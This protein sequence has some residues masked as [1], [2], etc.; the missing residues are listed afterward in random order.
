MKYALLLFLTTALCV[1]G[2]SRAEGDGPM[3][4][5]SMVVTQPIYTGPLDDT[6]ADSAIAY[7]QN[8]ADRLAHLRER[9]VENGD[10]AL[11]D[12]IDLLAADVD[13][14]VAIAVSGDVD[15]ALEAA[16]TILA[17][18]ADVL[19][20][21]AGN[22]DDPVIVEP[23][24]PDDGLDDALSAIRAR[25]DELRERL[26]AEDIQWA[27]PIVDEL[28]ARLDEIVA[29]AAAGDVEAARVEVHA[30]MAAIAEVAWQIGDTRPPVIEPEPTDSI[31][32]EQPSS[33]RVRAMLNDVERRIERIG[34]KLGGDPREWGFPLDDIKAR[35]HMA[36]TLYQAGEFEQALGEARLL[37]DDIRA[38]EDHINSQPPVP[39]DD[40]TVVI[41][42]PIDVDIENLI[43][44][45]NYQIETLGSM[46]EMLGI[47]IA[48]PLDEL[49][50]ELELAHEKAADDRAGALI[51]L[52]RVA[53]SYRNYV[54]AVLPVLGPLPEEFHAFADEVD[55]RIDI[56]A[57]SIGVLP[58]D[59][60]APISIYHDQLNIARDMY[61][62]GSTD[63]AWVIAN[64]IAHTIGMFYRDIRQMILPQEIPLPPVPADSAGV[65]DAIDRLAQ[66]AD[67]LDA[68]ATDI[69][70]DVAST[71]IDSARAHLDSAS[72]YLVAGD[73]GTAGRLAL[74]AH[75]KLDRTAELIRLAV[76]LPVRSANLRN[77]ID[78]LLT[79]AAGN[80]ITAANELLSHATTSLDSVDA[81]LADGRIMAADAA[82]IRALR[83]TGEA[84]Q[85]LNA[86][87][88]LSEIIP[89]LRSRIDSLSAVIEVAPVP[90]GSQLLASA[91]SALDKAE[92][93]LD[94]G[95]VVGA[96]NAV[97][98][99]RRDI[100]LVEQ[101]LRAGDRLAQHVEAISIYMEDTLAVLVQD[102]PDGRASELLATARTMRDT[103]LVLI[104]DGNT[105]AAEA[106]VRQLEHTIKQMERLI[107]SDSRLNAAIVTAQAMFE[108]AR[109]V[110]VASDD[111]LAMRHFN[112]ASAMLDKAISQSAGGHMQGAD[113][114]L[115]S[116]YRKLAQ[117]LFVAT[118]NVRAAEAVEGLRARVAAMLAAL[119][120]DAY[121]ERGAVV[122][123]GEIADSASALLTHANYHATLQMV[124]RVHRALDRIV[125][126][127]GPS[128]A[129]PIY[130]LLDHARELVGM[131]QAMLDSAVIGTA[132]GD[133]A[134]VLIGKAMGLV[135]QV[136]VALMSMSPMGPD[137]TTL[138][139][140]AIH[141]Q[142]LAMH[143][144][145][146]LSTD[147]PADAPID[148]A[149]YVA[150]E[151]DMDPVMADILFAA[152]AARDA[153]PNAVDGRPVPAALA[154]SNAPNPYNP[155]TTIQYE[156]PSAG[157]V[158]I[159]VHNLFGQEVRTLVEN[160]AEAGIHRVV[161]DGRDTTGRPMASGIYIARIV[162]PEG[163]LAI[164]MTMVR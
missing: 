34:T 63:S 101:L 74:L 21:L 5:D 147:V 141:A 44:W 158:R 152:R 45:L 2:V 77:T 116:A 58:I 19:A 73:L 89:A 30:L 149:G 91:G 110:I 9:A 35:L 43:S 41:P 24:G 103:A 69:A 128:P 131:A 37:L 113:A 17:E 156:L 94:S 6:L 143:A 36:W 115:Q 145:D 83:L 120:A 104:A 80:H 118:G 25:L 51:A 56:V 48:F 84:R 126:M 64:E 150:D 138:A 42:P 33:G 55:R 121:Y 27:L 61:T 1:V 151:I 96:E 122:R 40:S 52:A 164:R 139:D 57:R 95:Q 90:R 29:L 92:A 10:A 107:G 97:E 75:R 16:R 157:L 39:P 155:S 32:D 119:P 12:R 106:V 3:Y 129:P 88:R 14:L 78:S 85:L 153:G 54:D 124:E 62:A 102:L 133:S 125:I 142:R 99:A 11:V 15:A 105:F 20:L 146:I 66:V 8:I 82:L 76:Q 49:E 161:W 117:A 46:I 163:A 137:T 4:G 154:M 38:I 22:P 31:G 71:I 132:E 162:T 127:I 87:D 86:F 7:L 65:A 135:E 59:L 134:N 26:I 79:V 67:S 81:R 28:T 130:D 112:T 123:A 98:R 108:A 13:E 60:F 100:I 70:L 160:H 23:P 148:S 50:A 68:I 136:D 72:V 140:W 111:S 159:S 114:A 47:E 53:E 109:P 93:K 18:Y 144:I